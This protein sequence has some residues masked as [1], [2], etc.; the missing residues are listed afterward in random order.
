MV[1]SVFG[2][3]DGA[4]AGAPA[5]AGAASTEPG[6]VAVPATLSEA[7]AA[8][9]KAAQERAAAL[10][11][12]LRK[13]GATGSSSSGGGGGGGASSSLVDG[14][15][16]RFQ[17]P[18]PPV[19]GASGDKARAADLL[20]KAPREQEVAE[21]WAEIEI[22]D[23]PQTARWRVTNKVRCYIGVTAS[24]RGVRGGG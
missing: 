13:A 18:A 21:F 8:A 14:S 16:V 1:V 24:E 11:L 7:E 4:G 17:L 15:S 23:F 2:L 5:A 6:H 9:W 19:G 22:N 10:N 3:P 12:A 20:G